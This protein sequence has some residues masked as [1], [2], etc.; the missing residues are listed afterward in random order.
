MSERS[1]SRAVAAAQRIAKGLDALG[2]SPPL[3]LEAWVMIHKVLEEEF[4]A[5]ESQ[6]TL[7]SD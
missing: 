3:R 6:A 2:V 1:R 4:D 5:V 7:V